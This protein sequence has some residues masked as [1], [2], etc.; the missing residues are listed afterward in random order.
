MGIAERDT[1]SICSKLMYHKHGR[2]MPIATTEVLYV[3]AHV[4]KT[5]QSNLLTLFSLRQE[6]LKGGETMVVLHDIY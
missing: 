1:V 5:G 6:K 2:G 3:A 4:P